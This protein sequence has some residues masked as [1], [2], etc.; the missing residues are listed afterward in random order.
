M[1]DNRPSKNAHPDPEAGA[2]DSAEHKRTA[3]LP[4]GHSNRQK[5]LSDDGG[6]AGGVDVVCQGSSR[7]MGSSLD[8]NGKHSFL[9]DV[10]IADR[11]G[12]LMR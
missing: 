8:P 10:G 12:F 3:E 11:A 2:D 6:D 9:G 5:R 4:H 1:K 7:E